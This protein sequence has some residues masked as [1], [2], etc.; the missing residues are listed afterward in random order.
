MDT[1]F[2]LMSPVMSDRS[3]HLMVVEDVLSLDGIRD[4]WRGLEH[5]AFGPIEHFEWSRAC[6]ERLSELGR[7]KVF[8]IWDDKKCRAIAPFV[9]TPVGRRRLESLG[10]TQLTEPMDF[11]YEDRE[12]LARLCDA[13]ARQRLPIDLQRVPEVSPVTAELRRA[14]RGRGYVH[15]S[16]SGPYPTL[17]IDAS[18]K[19]PESHFNA[20]RRS[21]FRRAYRAAERFGSPE[22][23]IVTPDASNLEAL[24]AQAI[25]AELHSWKGRSGTA[26]ALD[27]L[28]A[29]IY[30]HYL[31]SICEKGLLRLGLM[32][33]DG[34]T[35]GMQIA[36]QTNQRL[37]L[38]KIGHNEEY[39]KCS[40]GTLLMLTLTRYAAEQ[41]L[42][43]I[44]FLGSA[45]PWTQLWTEE[46]R[47]CVRIRVYPLSLASGFALGED[48]AR[49]IGSTL[50]RRLQRGKH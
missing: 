25:E 47:A 3:R 15:V 14:F 37:W 32:R 24:L 38:L 45:E 44:E 33:I 13:L 4:A 29:Q 42:Q 7:L 17:P 49:S 34:K 41:Q 31:R 39:S 21:D 28:R 48:A 30:G 46:L 40:P 1:T 43:S 35:I 22:L 8:S 11:L 27:P 26:L 2:G 10:V 36:V 19:D 12:S 23:V 5:A 16:R 9:V 6:V 50:R 20:G 18:W